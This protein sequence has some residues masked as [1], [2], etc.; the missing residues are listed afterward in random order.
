MLISP[1][2]VKLITFQNDPP[3]YGLLY[4]IIK[5]ILTTYFMKIGENIYNCYEKE[6]AFM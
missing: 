3:F 6:T 5:L 4:T 1:Y 2:G